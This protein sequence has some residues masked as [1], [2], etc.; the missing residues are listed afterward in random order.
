MKITLDLAP[1]DRR[2]AEMRALL[3]IVMERLDVTPEEWARRVAREL[4][5]VDQERA[6]DDGD[7]T[8]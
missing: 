4:A 7:A 2:D 3:A 5:R 1:G 8:D 6:K